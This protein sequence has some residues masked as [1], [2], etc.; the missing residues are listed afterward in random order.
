MYLP[1]SYPYPIQYISH[2]DP[3]SADSYTKSDPIPK[4]K[5]IHPGWV[6]E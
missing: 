2:W 5:C 6:L 3:L 4:C 1:S